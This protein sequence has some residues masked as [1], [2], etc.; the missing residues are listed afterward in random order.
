MNPAANLDR[1]SFLKLGGAGV[2][3]LVVACCLPTTRIL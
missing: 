1:R 2:S 3:G